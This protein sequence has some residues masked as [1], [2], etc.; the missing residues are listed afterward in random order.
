MNPTGKEVYVDPVLTNVSIAYKNEAYVADQ[1]MPVLEVDK[2]S[3]YYYEYDKAQFR[4]AN[5]DRA[6]GARA[7]KIHYGLSKKTYGPLTEHSLETDVTVEDEKM[8]DTVLKP[9]TDATELVKEALLVSKEKG[10]STYM[11]NTANITQNVTLAGGQQWSDYANSDPIGDVTTA[12]KTVQASIFRRPNSIIMGSEVYYKLQHHPDLLERFKYSER[13]VLTVDHLKALFEVDNLYVAYA[14]ENSAKEGQ[15][16]ATADIWGKH[17]WVFYKEAR[18]QPKVVTFGF[19]LML[20]GSEQAEKWYEVGTKTTYVRVS[21]NYE[22]KPV[23]ALAC[24]LVKN[25][26]A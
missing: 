7:N 22:R 1:V 16:D 5:D 17:L 2:E 20:K 10:L 19:H 11:A 12:R 14:K 9:L 24:Y 21:M 26:V 3:G 13:G 18:V 6:P 23:A 15:T 4:V 25:A 8:A